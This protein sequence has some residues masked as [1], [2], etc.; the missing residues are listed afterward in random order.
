MTPQQIKELFSSHISKQ[1][2]IVV[3]SIGIISVGGGSINDTYQVKINDTHKFFLKLNSA[4]TLAG[5]FQK[6][7]NGLEFIARQNCIL[8]P[9]VFLC[10]TYHNHQWLLLE[11]IEPG[12]RNEDFWKKSGEQLACLHHCS[13]PHFGFPEDNFMGSLP[14][15]NTFTGNWTDFFIHY[16]LE[17]QINLALEKNHLGKNLAASFETLFKKL[18]S[19]FDNEKPS[20]LHG[21]LWNGNFMC[22]GQSSPV[23]IDPA[24]YF[25]HRSMDLAMTTLFGGFDKIFY[26]T[27]HYHFPLPANYHEQWE[28]CNLYPLLIHLNLFGKS[29]L[30]DITHTLK[31]LV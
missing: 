16:R 18:E 14:Q 21:D 24:V 1:L 3:S 4:T 30:A 23:L 31:K 19:I 5:L 10:E 22:S 12:T 28:V 8:T 2:N 27:Y 9:S 15:A 26:D 13:N 17:P 11:W 6:E 20:L 25:G 7:K 29:Y